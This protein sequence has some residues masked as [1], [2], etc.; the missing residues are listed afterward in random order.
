M[1]VLLLLSGTLSAQQNFLEVPVKLEIEKG[2]MSEVVI[3]VKKDGKDA[4]T[5]N[6]ASKL[7]FKL[8]FNRKY[9]LI[10]SKP[11][12]ISK[13][14]EVNTKAPS[15]RIASGFEPYK[16]GVKLFQQ[17]QENMVIYNQP[18]AQI[19]Y[20]QN[21]DEFNFDT[22]YSKSILSAINRDESEPEAKA[23]TAVQPVKDVAS[24]QEVQKSNPEPGKA[25]SKPPVAEKIQTTLATTP[26]VKD[27]AE[28]AS[29]QAA[30]ESP[31]AA[32]PVPAADLPPGNP[33]GTGNEIPPA[34]Q[35]AGGDNAPPVGQVAGGGEQP[36]SGNVSE[37]D[38]H[39]PV[40]A[41]MDGA[42]SPLKSGRFSSG[43]ER[44]A[45]QVNYNTAAEPAP[46]G[47]VFKESEH[48]TRED[49]V[50]RNRVITKIKITKNGVVTEYRRVNYSWGG[51][52]FFKNNTLSIPENLFVQWTGVNN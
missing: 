5:Q 4:F 10:F 39:K 24:T 14:I 7:R 43:D 52:Y 37:G 16:I 46:E 34:A 26:S 35:A 27:Q 40:A 44:Q 1:P 50:E 2:D 45:P 17:N 51:L 48:V 6:G 11:G 22:D 47:P 38:D 28:K 30:I 49:I 18:V 31:P 32:P 15:A 8:D 29:T 42:D 23:D 13:T 36:A 3:K 21:L 19:K 33:P 12:Y 9:T 25:E 41:K 20:D